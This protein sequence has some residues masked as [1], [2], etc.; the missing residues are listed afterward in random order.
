MN[1]AL[2]VAHSVMV[3][4]LLGKYPH[5]RRKGLLPALSFQLYFGGYDGWREGQTGSIL[6]YSVYL[7]VTGGCRYGRLKGNGGHVLDGGGIVRNARSEVKVA[8][9]ELYLG[10]KVSRWE[11]PLLSGWIFGSAGGNEIQ[12]TEVV[13]S[14]A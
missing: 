2:K 5:R 14:R 10:W 9:L 6:R 7:I 1:D 11:N 12:G 8:T 13:C 3:E 4:S